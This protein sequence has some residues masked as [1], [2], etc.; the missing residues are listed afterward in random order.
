MVRLFERLGLFREPMAGVEPQLAHV[1]R[2]LEEIALDP[3]GSLSD[4]QIERLIA[5]AQAA[6]TRIHEAAYQQ[7]HRDPVSRRAGAVDSRAASRRTSTR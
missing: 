1:E 7:L 5:A 3:D 2:A 4:A 6:R